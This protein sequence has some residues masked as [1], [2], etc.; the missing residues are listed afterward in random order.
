MKLVIA[1]SFLILSLM[2]VNSITAFED[3]ASE[4]GTP[5]CHDTAGTL[6]LASNST[7]VTTTAGSPFVLQIDA[8]NGAEWV[9]MKTGWADNDDF[10]MS[11]S[12]VEDD[13]ASD[14]NAVSGAITVV[15]TFTP[16]SAG[17]KTIRIWTAAGSDLA[18]SLDVTVNVTASTTTPTTTTPTTTT[19]PEPTIN[20]YEVWVQMMIWVP[21]ASGLILLFL[22]YIAI[23]RN[24]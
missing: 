9:S 12:H 21:I 4:C 3:Q 8:G 16:L 24:G 6:T 15:V 11:E 14:T 23:R 5:S 13:S 17:I 10:S 1:L 22:G 2:A 20:L 7:S 19:P 18:S